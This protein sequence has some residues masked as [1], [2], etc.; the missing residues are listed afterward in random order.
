MKRGAWQ[1]WQF[2]PTLVRDSKPQKDVKK[3]EEA[4]A[5]YWATISPGIIA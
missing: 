2:G 3:Q 1:G 5:A 4:P